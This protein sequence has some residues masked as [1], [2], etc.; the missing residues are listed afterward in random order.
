[1]KDES[2]LHE[3]RETAWRRPLTPEERAV[4]RKRLADEPEAAEDARL[5]ASLSAALAR[6]PDAPVP[7]NF[8]ARVLQEIERETSA[9]RP[10]ALRWLR[11]R[12]WL[13]RLALACMVLGLTLLG[14]RH[15][16]NANRQRMAESVAALS[17]VGT[18]PTPE[19]LADFDSIRRMGSMPAADTELLGLLQ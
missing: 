10:D 5:E 9:P 2:L 1:M 14:T 3:L 11:W 12:R 13:P 4:W 17:P 6:L 8:T 18:L 7:S 19:A 16:E 15:Y